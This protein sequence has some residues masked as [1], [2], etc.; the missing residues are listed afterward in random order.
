MVFRRRMMDKEGR[1]PVG[2]EY[3]NS[4]TSN[5]VFHNSYCRKIPKHRHDPEERIRER[6]RREEA[7]IE[8]QL[9]DEMENDNNEDMPREEELNDL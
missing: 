9:R 7:K 3:I 4:Y 6:E 8:S 2:Y 1:C 5:G